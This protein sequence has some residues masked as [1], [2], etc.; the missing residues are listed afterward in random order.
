ML[1]QY[2]ISITHLQNFLDLILL[3]APEPTKGGPHYQHRSFKTNITWNSDDGTARQQIDSA[4]YALQTMRFLVKDIKSLVLD[5]PDFHGYVET[6]Y[7]A[8]DL[9]A[10]HAIIKDNTLTLHV[11]HVLRSTKSFSIPE[12]PFGIYKRVPVEQDKLKP[13]QKYRGIILLYSSIIN[14]SY[15]L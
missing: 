15:L 12:R 8:L 13:G 5:V 7:W 1:I 9:E 4:N 14:S 2:Q 11:D 6:T 3:F 10:Q